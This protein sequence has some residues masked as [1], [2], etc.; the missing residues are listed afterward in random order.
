MRPSFFSDDNPLAQLA[1]TFLTCLTCL[2]LFVY[3]GSLLSF[4]FYHVH[5]ADLQMELENSKNVELQK[6]F[7]L[8]QGIGL[9]MIP[10]LIL[11][12]LFTGK[13]FE[14]LR[15]T[16][17]PTGYQ[18]LL[19]LVIAIFSIP[20]INLL[21]ELNAMIK[22][23]ASMSGIQ[24]YIDRT[25]KT[26]QTISES[27]LRV[28]SIKGLLVNLLIVA[29]V[30][31]I[32]EEFLFRGVL[33]RIFTNWFRNAH[34]GIFISA[35]VFSA[36]HMEFYG[37]FPRLLLG[38]M[39]GYFLYWSGSI[40][41]SILGHF[42]NNAVAVIIFYLITNSIVNEKMADIGSTT[43]ILPYTIICCTFIGAGIFLLSKKKHSY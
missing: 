30:P 26:Y 31:A 43:E 23:P 27:F 40:W 12:K 24:N 7:Q 28:S 39:F 14:Y 25:S 19:V 35:F 18:F 3:L 9:F 4:Y 32:G 15:L 42:I 11:G 17:I 8:I 36:I 38:M 16:K 33:Q 2:F 10:P 41:L 34:W 20:V 21:A 5:P 22:F 29:V 6:F 1:I 37:F 13:S